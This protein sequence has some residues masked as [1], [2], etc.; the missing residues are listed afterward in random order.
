MWANVY[1][2]E[3]VT[4]GSNNMIGR[5][6][7]GLFYE[8]IFVP[9]STSI[10]T[11]GYSSVFDNVVMENRIRLGHHVTIKSS[12]NIGSDTTLG[13]YTTVGKYDNP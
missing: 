7:V 8:E 5:I 9:F 10:K 13:D 2:G 12:S 11:G 4:I 6:F 1:I 3:S